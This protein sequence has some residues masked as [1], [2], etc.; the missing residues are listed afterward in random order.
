[1][2]KAN[3]WVKI[4]RKILETEL[5][6]SQF[7]FF[8]GAILL[9]KTLNSPNPGLVDLSVRQLADE[10]RM[11]RSEVWRRE[12]ELEEM[13][14]LTLLDK[15]F[16]INNYGYYQTGKGVPPTGHTK[17]DNS[18][19]T[20]SP[21]GQ[22]KETTVPPTGLNVPPT[23]LNVPPEGQSVPSRESES[24]NKNSKKKKNIKKNDLSN[25]FNIFW[26]AYPRKV[27]K[28]DA[29]KAFNGINPNEQLFNKILTAI[30]VAKKSEGWLKENG[31]YILYPTTWLNGK[32]WEDE[33]AVIATSVKSKFNDG[34]K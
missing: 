24:D 9:A 32:R 14:M 26:G 11:S 13:E 22:E 23:G 16:T 30:G 18:I 27:A 34:W 15:G 19:T 17:V 6:A 7:K 1:M 21:T 29:E 3:G 2:P 10:L 25:N 8:V 4:H 33:V 20:V 31:K 28:K 5:T 12:K